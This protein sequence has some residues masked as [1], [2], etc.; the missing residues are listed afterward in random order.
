MYPSDQRRP[1]RLDRRIFRWYVPAIYSITR[2]QVTAIVNRM[3]GRSADTA[4]MDRHTDELRRFSDVEGT[5]WAYLWRPPTLTVMI[6][7]TAQRN[8]LASCKPMRR[9]GA[10]NV[11]KFRSLQ[12]ARSIWLAGS[13]QALRGPRLL[14][15]AGAEV[16]WNEIRTCLLSE[17]RCCAKNSEAKI[18]E[19]E[20]HT[21]PNPFGGVS[22]RVLSFGCR[23]PLTFKESLGPVSGCCKEQRR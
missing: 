18:A 2:A 22:P 6:W 10:F 23:L 5:H 13:S 19:V 14:W 11:I 15:T 7:T 16:W 3:L 17:L 8:G 9:E 21:S 4:Y 12:D 1:V 20:Q